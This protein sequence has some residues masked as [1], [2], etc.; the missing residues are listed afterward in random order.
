MDPWVSRVDRPDNLRWHG[1]DLRSFTI[2]IINNPPGKVFLI[3]SNI[4]YA[5]KLE[6]NVKFFRVEKKI[7]PMSDMWRA[8]VWSESN[9]RK[10][11][12]RTDNLQV[13]RER[14]ETLIFKYQ[15]SLVI[16]HTIFHQGESE[17]R[18]KMDCRRL[19]IVTVA[20]Q[21]R[22]LHWPRTFLLIN[23]E[24]VIKWTGTEKAKAIGFT[25]CDGTTLVVAG[26]SFFCLFCFG[27]AAERDKDGGFHVVVS[28]VHKNRQQN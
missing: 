17:R 2:I 14:P 9:L 26:C 25:I 23:L 6:T 22:Y 4:T 24:Q 8:C 19:F 10:T 20:G 7:L 15:T 21:R 16:T 12:E 5:Q 13:M 3:C 18:K 28:V 27:E 11:A 1:Q